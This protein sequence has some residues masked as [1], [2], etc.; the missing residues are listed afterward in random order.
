[1]KKWLVFC[2]FL[3]HTWNK[4]QITDFLEENPYIL[5]PAN[6]A[7]DLPGRGWGGGTWV[8]VP[9]RAWTRPSR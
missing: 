8:W 7:S 2:L 9:Q 4:L 5:R 3:A 6:Y 1:M